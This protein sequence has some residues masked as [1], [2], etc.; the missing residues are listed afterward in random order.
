MADSVESDVET[1]WLSLGQR[2][3]LNHARGAR[4]VVLLDLE[5]A[6]CSFEV[7]LSNAPV[8]EALLKSDRFHVHKVSH[9]LPSGYV[10]TRD[11]SQL[12]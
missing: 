4:T 11:L 12:R 10:I 3:D 8:L 1:S 9:R 7:D 6:K 5:L 2:Q